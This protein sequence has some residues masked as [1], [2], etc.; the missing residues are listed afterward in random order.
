MCVYSVVMDKEHLSEE[1]RRVLY[2]KKTEAPFSG[3]YINHNEEGFYICAGCGTRLFASERKF[4]SK[5]GWPSF[6][7]AMPGA[8]HQAEDFSF[9][10]KR[11]EVICANCGGHLGHVFN[12]GP[13]DTTGVRYCINSLALDFDK[14]EDV[15]I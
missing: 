2:E 8:L 1:Q 5:S 3:K 10:V 12:D 7:D 13:K 14:V 4:E 6:D 9:G 15:D 11:T